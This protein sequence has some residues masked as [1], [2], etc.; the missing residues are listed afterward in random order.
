MNGTDPLLQTVDVDRATSEVYLFP[1]QK[2]NRFYSTVLHFSPALNMKL[3]E[4]DTL[5][6]DGFVVKVRAELIT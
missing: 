5:S 2:I 6:V 1:S 4:L 3:S